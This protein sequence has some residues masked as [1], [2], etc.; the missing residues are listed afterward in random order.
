M[1]AENLFP[2]HPLVGSGLAQV[3]MSAGRPGDALARLTKTL[4]TAPA[5]AD[6]A[7]AGDAYAQLGRAHEAERSYK[8]AE[9]MW[10]SDTPEPA[11]LAR[12]LATRG[13]RLAD[14]VRLGEE[15][16]A[17]RQDIY[18]ADALAWA[19]FK[20]GRLE[21]AHT[22]MT[23]ALSTGSR[24]PELRRHADEISAARKRASRDR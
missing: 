23:R 14:A 1:R 20:Q 19:Y 18:T 2:G 11:Q 22:A 10:A 8:L 7:L 13:W 16:F 21:E 5:A 4:E 17:T 3:D 24:D 15:A 9:A 6:F 12:F